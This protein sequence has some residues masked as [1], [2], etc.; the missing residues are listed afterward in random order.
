M[1]EWTW[2]TYSAAAVSAAQRVAAVVQ[3]RDGADPDLTAIQDHCRTKIAGY[4]VPRQLN[5]VG[6]MQRSP[7][8]KADYRWAQSVASGEIGSTEVR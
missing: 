5:V 3:L 2:H 6:T 8:G 1:R 4:K 7:S